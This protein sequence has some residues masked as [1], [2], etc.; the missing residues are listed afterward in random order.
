MA[1]KA[2][3]AVIMGGRQ[4][5]GNLFIGCGLVIKDPDF[6]QSNVFLKLKISPV[7]R[8]FS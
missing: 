6:Y 2:G 1:F 4:F 3:Q 8:E 7:L 5:F